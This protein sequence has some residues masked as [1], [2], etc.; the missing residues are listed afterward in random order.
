MFNSEH[1]HIIIYKESSM[2][3]KGKRSKG[4][5]RSKNRPDAF[6]LSRRTW[7]VLAVVTSLLLYGIYRF[8]VAPFTLRWQALYGEINTPQGY[9]IHGIDISHHQGSI[10]W[11]KLGRNEVDKNPLSFVII[12]ATEGK[13]LLDKNFGYNFRQAGEYLPIRG[14]YHFFSPSVTGAE[15]AENFIRNVRLEEGDLPPVLDIEQSGKLSTDELRREALAWLERTEQ[16]YGATPIIY[17]YYKFKMKYLNTPEFERYP[18]WIAHYYVD[19]L[20][21]EGEWKFWQYTDCGKLDGIKGFV[22]LN[23]YNGS[24]YDLRQLTIRRPQTPQED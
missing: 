11:E 10:D 20:R 23:I 15:Q 22:D 7:I 14:A 16:E 18:Y 3:R 13:T 17:T 21:Y 8:A 19:K 24:M 6:G 1:W 4:K 2:S 9:T 5:N 12:K